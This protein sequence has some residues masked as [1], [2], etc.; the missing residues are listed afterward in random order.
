VPGLHLVGVEDGIVFYAREGKPLDAQRLVERDALPPNC[1]GND[2][3]LLAGVHIAG[4]VAVADDAGTPR[5]RV[6]TYSCVAAP[7]NV[8]VAVRCVVNVGN[9]KESYASDFQPLGQFIWPV[10]R[11]NTNKLYVDDFVVKLPADLIR[12][13]TSVS[14]EAAVLAP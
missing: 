5:V 7:T 10:S 14:F 8:D 13:I 2:I 4:Y 6:T 1:V 3:P 12:E 9:R 11:W